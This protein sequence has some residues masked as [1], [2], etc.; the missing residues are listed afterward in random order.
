METPS[1]LSRRFEQIR[2]SERGALVTFIT[3]GDPNP[4]ASAH[5]LQRLPAAGADI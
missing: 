5:L 2:A 1:R 4:S 3:A